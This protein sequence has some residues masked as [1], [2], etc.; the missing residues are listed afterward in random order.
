[1]PTSCTEL[2]LQS[3]VQ[4]WLY[5]EQEYEFKVV[6]CHQELPAEFNH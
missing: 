4:E 3:E 2:A 5:E 1:M 6:E